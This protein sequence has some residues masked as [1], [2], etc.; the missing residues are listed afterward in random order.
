MKYGIVFLLVS[1]CISYFAFH[2]PW[3][4]ILLWPAVAFFMVS[5]AYFQNSANVFWKLS[6]GTRPV[7]ATWLLLPYLAFARIVWEIQVLFDSSDPLNQVT[8]KLIIARRLKAD[9]FPQDVALV[10]DLTSEFVDPPLVRQH[11]GYV[12]EPVL[13]A[14]AI[15]FKKALLLADRA[16]EVEGKVLIHCANGSG[17][18]GHVSAIFLIAW[19]EAKSAADAIRMVQD[20]RPCVSLNAKQ[21]ETVREAYFY[22]DKIRRTVIGFGADE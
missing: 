22:V 19:R 12:A 13:D 8:E 1:S 20:A 9:E 17:R 5:Q 11:P 6:N 16:S 14:A 18:S 7:E 2:S 4:L 21:V 15:D 3:H 10:I